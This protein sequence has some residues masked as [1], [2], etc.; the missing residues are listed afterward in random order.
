MDA[1]VAKSAVTGPDE[2]QDADVDFEEAGDED[3]GGCIE[4]GRRRGTE[5]G[6]N[7]LSQGACEMKLKGTSREESF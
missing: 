2:E 4:G 1:N 6:E 5:R 7:K 3:G